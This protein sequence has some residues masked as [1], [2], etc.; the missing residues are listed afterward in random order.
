MSLSA[1]SLCRPQPAQV[2]FWQVWHLS[3]QHIAV[4]RGCCWGMNKRDGSKMEIRSSRYGT[5]HRSKIRKEAK[6]M[7]LRSKS[8]PL[9][10]LLFYLLFL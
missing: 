4:F 9:F 10:Q 3:C 5:I 2:G 1:D 8:K 6:N 7:T